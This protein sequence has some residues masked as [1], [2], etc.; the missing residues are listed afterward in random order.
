MKNPKM[1]FKCH[2][3]AIGNNDGMSHVTTNIIETSQK[4]SKYYD[5]IN[6]VCIHLFDW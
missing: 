4:R 6:D 5:I 1:H 2:L 3:E